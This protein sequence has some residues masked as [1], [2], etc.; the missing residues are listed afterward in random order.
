MRGKKYSGRAFIRWLAEK[1]EKRKKIVKMWH[2]V[3]KGPIRSLLEM[4]ILR[5]TG[6]VVKKLKKMNFLNLALATRNTPMWAKYSESR[7]LESIWADH[8]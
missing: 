3:G 5:K 2:S 4:E 6:E 1:S 8:K 7:L